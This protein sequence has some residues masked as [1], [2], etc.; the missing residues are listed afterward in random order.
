MPKNR[1]IPIFIPHCGCPNMCVFCDQRTIAG[2]KRPPSPKEVAALISE[3]LSRSGEGAELA[4]YGGSF[5]A[6]PKSLQEGYLSA[7]YGFVR[8]GR[9]SGIRLSTRPDA[10]APD[11]P[12]FLKS[13]GVH[14]VELGAQSMEDTA[15]AASKR[16]HT[17]LDTERASQIIKQGGLELVLQ[18][19]PGLPGETDPMYSVLKA[20]ELEPSGVR[21]YPVVVIEGTELARMY[22]EG[23]YTPLSIERAADICADASEIFEARG[24]TVIRCG[25]NPSEGLEPEV[26][27]GAYH[28]AFGE[29][30]TSRR[31][32]RRVEGMLKD[33]RGEVLEITVEPRLLSAAV[34]NK[35]ENITY[36]KE[37]FGFKEVRVKQGAQKNGL[38]INC[39]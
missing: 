5:T 23:S 38:S 33:A 30:V 25:L 8:E 35:R 6:I 3:G 9:L 36:F 21:L 28:P 14:T 31:I 20:A 2:V 26:V 10:I 13:Y 1:I 39:Y 22:R 7:A 11:T 37:R 29:L 27:A 12:E 18:L 4:F 16:G 34:G 15:L 32:R 19:M 17:A 24:I